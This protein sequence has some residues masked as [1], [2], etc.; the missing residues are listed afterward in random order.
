MA[1]AARRLKQSGTP[2]K[3]LQVPQKNMDAAAQAM[4][5][6]GVGGTVKNMGGTKRRSV[7]RSADAFPCYREKI[8]CSAEKIP[9]SVA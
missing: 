5:N 6:V 9:C 4:R 7:P 8:P 1:A 3:V 2:Q